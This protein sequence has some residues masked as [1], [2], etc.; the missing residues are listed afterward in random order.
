MNGKRI[1]KFTPGPWAP[2]I[3]TYPV[4]DTGEYDSDHVVVANGKAIGQFFTWLCGPSD[5]EAIANTHLASAAPEMY[6]LLKECREE[7]NDEC[8]IVQDLCDRIDTVLKKARG[9][10]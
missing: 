9:E 5:D 4:A 10:Q 7:F 2:D 1:E 8:H 6:A 3:E